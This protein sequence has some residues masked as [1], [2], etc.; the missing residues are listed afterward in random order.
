M[1]LAIWDQDGKGLDNV[2][3]TM[4]SATAV[5]M[6]PCKITLMENSASDEMIGDMIFGNGYS[7]ILRETT[8]YNTGRTV[9]ETA[10]RTLAEKYQRR[11]KKNHF[12]E[13][14]ENG[15]YYLPQPS[16]P[17]KKTFDYSFNNNL[18]TFIDESEE[19][20][21]YTM[22]CTEKEQCLSSP[23]ILDQADMVLVIMSLSHRAFVE[24]LDK[25][26]SIINKCM[27][28]IMKPFYMD[29]LEVKKL[30]SN[31]GISKGRLVIVPCTESLE[32]HIQK[33]KVVDY[34]RNNIN[35]SRGTS[36]YLLINRLKKIAH[37]VFGGNYYGLSYQAQQFNT[38][39]TRRNYGEQ[40]YKRLLEE[41]E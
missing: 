38:L 5:Y 33:G 13:V 25:Y 7:E 21:D 27:L 11:I 41:N 24:F 35:C 23:Y 15:L 28:I 4:L 26:H 17:N 3:V 20:C 34:I 16:D 18:Y 19:I 8:V 30:F 6:H 2:F 40:S 9:E 1:L 37:A 12:L 39:L 29:Q 31:L 22:I 32:I 36:E 10:A 14:I